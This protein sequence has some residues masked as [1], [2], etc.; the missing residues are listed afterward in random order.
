[1]TA[2]EC[3]QN[4]SAVFKAVKSCTI[5]NPLNPTFNF[6]LRK[7]TLNSLPEKNSVFQNHFLGNK[8]SE[9]KKKIFYIFLLKLC[10]LFCFICLLKILNQKAT[11]SKEI[12]FDV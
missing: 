10:L 9:I 12:G 11:V 8:A 2:S 4:F 7:F 5:F 3:W 6:I 1:M